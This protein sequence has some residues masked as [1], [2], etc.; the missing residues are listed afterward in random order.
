[1]ALSP[2]FLKGGMLLTQVFEEV[3]SDKSLNT[4]LTKIESESAAEELKCTN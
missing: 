2:N 4:S 1:M 3:L